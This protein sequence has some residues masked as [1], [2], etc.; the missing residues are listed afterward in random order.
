MRRT[1]NWQLQ[2]WRSFDA[3]IA[4]CQDL[5]NLAAQGRVLRA[6]HLRAQQPREQLGQ[7]RLELLIVERG[8]PC[9]DGVQL[10][11]SG[12]SAGPPRPRPMVELVCRY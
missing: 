2:L 8:Q 9:Q 4:V 3:L 10:G 6:H 12:H 11:D 1:C 5:D 7:R